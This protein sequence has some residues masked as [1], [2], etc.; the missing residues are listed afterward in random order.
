MPAQN[1]SAVIKT[2]RVQHGLSQE[3]LA[4]RAGLTREFVSMIEH[5]RR[6]P[7]QEALGKIAACFGKETVDLLQ[8][9]DGAEEKLQLAI[10]L[11]KIADNGNREHLK[12]LVEFAQTLKDSQ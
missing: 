7:S 1:M 5:G 9:L 3:E 10:T 8:E 2:N 12:R 11:R 4:Q 6:N